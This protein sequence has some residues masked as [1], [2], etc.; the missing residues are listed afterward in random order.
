[1]SHPPVVFI[2]STSED[3]KDH[4]EQ[5]AKAARALGFHP[6]MMEDWSASGRPSVE[7]CLARVAKADVV[8]AIV[9]QRYGWVPD[10]TNPKSIT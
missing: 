9:A 8:V 6:E 4:R 5:A 1:M 2:S 7:A 10:D 3:L